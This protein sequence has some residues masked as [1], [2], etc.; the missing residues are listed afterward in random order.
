M[1]LQPGDHVLLKYRTGD[2]R[3]R[4]AV[5]LDKADGTYHRILTPAR[6]VRRVDFAA[7]DLDKI[8]AWDGV[9]PPKKLKAK[10]MFLDSDSVEGKFTKDE[11]QAEIRALSGGRPRVRIHGKSAL[12]IADVK[13]GDADPAS[14]GPAHAPAKPEPRP[15]AHSGNVED[16]EGWYLLIGAGAALSGSE[17]KIADKK[18]V[19]LGQLALVEKGDKILVAVWAKAEELA[20]ALRG[21]RVRGFG[22][23]SARFDKVEGDI[24]VDPDARRRRGARRRAHWTTTKICAFSRCTT[25]RTAAGFDGYRMLNWTWT[26]RSSTTGRCKRSGRSV[27]PSESFVVRICPGCSTTISGCG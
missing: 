7:A 6:V 19:I 13:P 27:M 4:H 12:S 20:E 24:F 10:D 23:P 25:R 16:G 1:S 2:V 21:L 14:P 11:I 5:I 9:T 26:R 3:W 17:V 15:R 18:H 22:H 8:A